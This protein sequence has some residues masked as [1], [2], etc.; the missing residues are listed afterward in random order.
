[1]FYYSDTEP[2]STTIKQ[3]EDSVIDPHLR[4]GVKFLNFNILGLKK[5]TTYGIKTSNPRDVMLD[6]RF[7]LSATKRSINLS[8]FN[9]N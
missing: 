7:L 3:M 5:H 6:H 1:M 9:V 2:N 4:T 8:M